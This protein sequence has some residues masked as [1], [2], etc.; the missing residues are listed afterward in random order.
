MPHYDYKCNACA[1][2]KEFVHKMSE[3]PDLT[4]TCGGVYTRIYLSAPAVTI[5]PHMQSS[6][7]GRTKVL[8]ATPDKSK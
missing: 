7:T 2:I 4:C 1:T 6:S 5:P 3:I 8:P